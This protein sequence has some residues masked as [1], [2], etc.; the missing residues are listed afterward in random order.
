MKSTIS[1]LQN[2]VE[3][4]DTDHTPASIEVD[5]SLERVKSI[6][7]MIR[8]PSDPEPREEIIVEPEPEIEI[9]PEVEVEVEPEPEV[10]EEVVEEEIDDEKERKKEIRRKIISLYEGVEYV[11]E[12]EKEE[13]KESEV[14]SER[15]REQ[16]DYTPTNTITSQIGINDRLLLANELF[17]GDM[18]AMDNCL[19]AIERQR[20]FDD[21]L[22]Y[23]AENYSWRGEGE[24]AK[25]LY[26]LLENNY[27]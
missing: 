2:I 8:F 24:G 27:K 15:E 14:V 22:L 16:M 21:A 6:Y 17:E 9:E 26:T 25:L 4:W 11:N 3:S 1:E 20:C 23:I 10:E 18:A 19:S 13:G 5:M 7:E 12:Q